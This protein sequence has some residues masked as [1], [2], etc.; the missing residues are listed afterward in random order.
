M[1][2]IYFLLIAFLSVITW[3]TQAQTVYEFNTDNDTEGWGALN[4]SITGPAGGILNFGITGGTPK[5]T[6]A[7]AGVNSANVYATIVIKNNSNNAYLRV[8]Y[9]KTSGGRVYKNTVITTND[10]TYKTYNIDLTNSS[11]TG[12]IDDIQIHFK[13]NSSTNAETGGSVDFDKISFSSTIAKSQKASWDFEDNLLDGWADVNGST[14]MANGQLTLTPNYDSYTK[15][16]QLD[17]VV[18]ADTYGFLKLVAKNESADNDQVRVIGNGNTIVNF[19]I[20]VSDATFKT[21]IIKLDGS[22]DWTGDIDEVTLGIKDSQLG[23]KAN[24]GDFII[25]SIDFI[26][27]ESVTWTGTTDTDWATTTNW[28]G[29][30]VPLANYD[31]TIPNVVNLPVISAST[32]AVCNDL[33]IASGAALNLLSDAS[34]SASLKLGGT[35]SGSSTDINYNRYLVDN[36]WHLIGSPFSGETISNAYISANSITG[37]KDYIEST[38]S[39]ATDYVPANAPDIAFVSGKGYAAKINATGFIAFTGDPVIEDKYTP[40]TRDNNGWNLLSNPFATAVAANLAGSTTNNIL[41]DNADVLDPSFTALYIWDNSTSQYV[42]INHAGGSPGVSLAQD[43]LQVGQGFFVKSIDPASLN[44]FKVLTAMQM[45]KTDAAFKS[46]EDSKMAITLFAESNSKLVNTQILYK[47][48]MSKGLDV[49][50]DAG[51]FSSNPEFSIYSRLIDDNGVD[52]MLQAV[53]INFEETV[54]PI[55]IE[56]NANEMISFS[57][58][59]MN[60]PEDYAVVLEDKE[61]GVFTDLTDGAKY[62]IQPSSNLSGTGRFYVHTSFKSTLGIGDIDEFS[63]QVFTQANNNQLVI[64]GEST[65]NTIA[66]VYSI[67]GKLVAETNLLQSVENKLSFNEDAGVYIVQISNERGTFNQKFAWVK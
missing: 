18:D 55:G 11:W 37:M 51:L 20:S 58:Q 38:D 4:A 64:R 32:A 54:I 21:Y 1:K 25:E 50:Y 7:N 60:I 59:A 48:N 8:S 42:I 16:E 65:P 46:T 9:P 2:K 62:T 67:T 14:A 26:A 66:R 29:G 57:A 30:V 39:W 53:P 36:D 15:L 35:Y 28:S 61:L 10:V 5:L 19:P 56:A 63:F 52:F 33:T 45:E 12:T 47:E 22:V 34:N 43:Y 41:T 44:S 3:N 23:G 31:I 40:L 13:L 17:Y 49:G 27:A 6:Q 24:T